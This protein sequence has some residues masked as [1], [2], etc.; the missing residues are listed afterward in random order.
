MRRFRFV[1]AL[2]SL[3]LLTLLVFS[4]SG[5]PPVEAGGDIESE[6][7]M[8]QNTSFVNVEPGTLG[9]SGTGEFELDGDDLDDLEFELE[10]EANGLLPNTLSCRTG[11]RHHSKKTSFIPFTR[12]K[13][14]ATTACTCVQAQWSN[15]TTTIS[16]LDF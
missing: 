12:P 6:F 1:P 4:M 16:A 9:A 14:N 13:G 7:K 3:A 10:V 5:A 15:F 8:H 11:L 2:L